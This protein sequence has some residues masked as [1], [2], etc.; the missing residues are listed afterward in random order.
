[1]SNPI[2]AS[3]QSSAVVATINE[4]STKNPWVYNET[5]RLTVPHAMQILPVRTSSGTIAATSTATFDLPKNGIAQQLWLD[6]AFSGETHVSAGTPYHE[7]ESIKAETAA[8]ESS[9][10][11]DGSVY[12]TSMG[13]LDCI[14]EVR[15]SASGRT[16]EKLD[17]YQMLA[18][19]SEL[20]DGVRASVAKA[21][22]MGGTPSKGKYHTPVLLPFWFSQD[23]QRYGLLTNFEEPF[24]VEVQFNDCYCLVKQGKAHDATAVGGVFTTGGHAA[25]L[26]QAPFVNTDSKLLVHYRQL[27]EPQMNEVVSKNYG[28]GL[29]SRVVNISKREAEYSTQTPLAA[30]KPIEC[31]LKENEAVRAMYIV[32]EKVATN[33]GLGATTAGADT[34][35]LTVG[36]QGDAEKTARIH[37]SPLP[38]ESVQLKFNSTTVLDV[39]GELLKYYG[40]WGMGAHCA[41]GD[42]GNLHTQISKMQYVYKIDFGLGYDKSLSNVV[43][44]RELSNPTLTVNIQDFDGS[45]AAITTSHRVHV[46]YDTATF[47]STSSSTGRV[48]LSISS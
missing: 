8:A 24:R 48:Q 1:M 21:L 19:Y 15:I 13:V 23:Q 18:R 35:T 3:N 37:S 10:A 39:P 30:G 33:F 42:G 46:I 34:A 45:Q 47:L 28:D 7:G 40:R 17:K 16:I 38:I 11:S 2:L 41:D 27:D 43:A 32:V 14:K 9:G 12:F 26:K 22:R 25:K 31:K 44:F 4:S 36:V 20:P 5:D 29:L 6:L